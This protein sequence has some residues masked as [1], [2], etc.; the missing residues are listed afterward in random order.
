MP[1]DTYF[2]ADD[3]SLSTFAAHSREEYNLYNQ[4]SNDYSYLLDNIILDSYDQT[5][6]EIYAFLMNEV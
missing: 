5:M 2:N 3:I 6:E 1:E 4:L